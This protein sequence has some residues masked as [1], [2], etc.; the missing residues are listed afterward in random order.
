MKSTVVFAPKKSAAE[1]ESAA[2]I[3]TNSNQKI[4]MLHP[5]E[6][7]N[8][9]ASLGAGQIATKS[10]LSDLAEACGKQAGIGGWID[11]RILYLSS[12]CIVWHRPAATATMHFTAAAKIPSGQCMQPHLI[13]AVTGSRWYVWAVRYESKNIDL[14]PNANTILA[15]TPH[16][17]VH[18]DG[19]ICTGNVKL[20]KKLSPDTV[21]DFENA[22]FD[23]RFTHPNHGATA[24]TGK[25]ASHIWRKRIGKFTDLEWQSD[26]VLTGQTLGDVVNRIN[27]G[28]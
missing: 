20:P 15:H 27:K 26:L 7:S 2:L 17:N 6:K 8:G 5:V 23:S 16:F 12:D 25:D 4:I 22:F 13:F 10:Q 24:P 14:R 21:M 9:T 28:K 3:Y 18:A 11:P 19:E 1:L